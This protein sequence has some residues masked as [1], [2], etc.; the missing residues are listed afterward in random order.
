MNTY[1]KNCQQKKKPKNSSKQ[2]PQKSFKK[3][4]SSLNFTL[5]KGLCFFIKIASAMRK[6]VGFKSE[7]K[8]EKFSLK[9][10]SLGGSME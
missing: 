7:N 4:K 5:T 3:S 1:L 10:S 8:T 6:L 2:N 9:D